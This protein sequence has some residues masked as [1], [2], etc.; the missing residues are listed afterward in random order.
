ML[1]SDH[2]ILVHIPVSLAYAQ[3]AQ[4]QIYRNFMQGVI[5][6]TRPSW[7]RLVWH[8]CY[9]GVQEV[10]EARITERDKNRCLAWES[11]SDRANHT[12]LTFNPV[13]ADVTLIHLHT[14][15]EPLSVLEDIGMT[16]GAVSQRIEGDLQRFKDLVEGKLICPSHIIS[17]PH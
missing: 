10:W 9:A 14:E 5:K 1:I 7:N 2:S 11:V 16:L 8:V 3:W 17:C 13:A 6:V 12:R 15:Y 4:P